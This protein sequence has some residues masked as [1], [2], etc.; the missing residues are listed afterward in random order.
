MFLTSYLL[1]NSNQYQGEEI[2]TMK[3]GEDLPMED[4]NKLVIS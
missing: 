3:L 1:K 4:Y 2:G